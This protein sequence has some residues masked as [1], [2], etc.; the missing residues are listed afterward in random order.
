[1]IRGIDVSKWQGNIDWQKVKAAGI[2]FAIIRAGY[3]NSAAQKDQ[4]FEQNY[5]GAKA[6]GLHVGAYWYSY[7]NSFREAIQEAE[8]FRKVIAGKQFDMPVYLDM[9]EK[10]QLEAGRD[11]CSG[12]IRTFCS[13]MEK[14]GYYAGFYTSASYARTV[15]SPE[16]ISRYTFWCAQ[17]ADHCSY[18]G[19][20]GIW[21]HSSKGRVA[22]IQGDVDLDACY[23]DFPKVIR[24]GGFNGYPKNSMAGNQTSG[25]GSTTASGQRTPTDRERVV[26]QARAWLGRKESDGSFREI[27]DIYNAH[28]PLPRGYAVKYTDAWCATFVSAVAI[29]C[30]VTKI[31]PP[32]CGCGQML[33]LFKILGE[34]V[35]DDAYRPK[36]GDVIF[37]DWQDSGVGDDTG[38]PDHVGIV[39]K[40]EGDIITV[41]EGNKNDAVGRRVLQ[42]NGRYIRAYGVP[43]YR[44]QAND[45]T[46]KPADAPAASAPARRM[47]VEEAARGVIAG[48]YGNGADRRKAIETIGL[49]YD[50]VQARVN[51]I[52]K[53]GGKPKKTVDQVAREVI[54]R[55]WG[56]GPQRRQKLKQAG[57]DYR[58]VQ[59]RVNQLMK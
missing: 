54:R 58:A 25:G 2:E 18:M 3:G 53:E 50:A 59:K 6:A 42:V 33:I 27:I 51:A 32:E 39:E 35:E 57:Y 20:C 56:T 10:G 30:G 13:E 8:A 9:E 40:V 26:E 11:F 14:A 41:I 17:W 19:R 24:K 1:M 23:Q 43:K 16:I 55:L 28:K 45:Q 52:L 31:I 7:A 15:V 44:E 48:K 21:Q 12:L 29:R 22:G 4:F 37:Y 34:L 49:N 5:R 38:W 36:P 47:S 46:A